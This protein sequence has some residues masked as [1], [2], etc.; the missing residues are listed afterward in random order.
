MDSNVKDLIYLLSCAIKN[1]VP[2]ISEQMDIDALYKL[3]AYHHLSAVLSYSL[4][5]AGIQDSR[6]SSSIARSI[7]RSVIMEGEK[8][9]L[10]ARLEDAGI[11]YAPL[12]GA[13]LK[14]YYPKF[15]MR[16]M[17]DYD[18]LVAADRT[19]DVKDIMVSLGFTVE[20]YDTDSNHDVY[21]KQPVTNFEIHRALFRNF[22]FENET[23][24]FTAYY[25]RVWDILIKDED[26]SCGYHFSNEDFY[27]YMLAHEN[28]H[29]VRK[30]IGIRALLDVFV[31]LRYFPV[32][33]WDHINAGLK[34]LGIVEFE[35]KIRRLSLTLFEEGTVSDEAM[36]DYMLG[37]GTYGNLSNL[38]SNRMERTGSKVKYV[39]KRLIVPIETVKRSYPY[40]YKHRI[41]L[42]FVPIIRVIRKSREG[43]SSVRAEI[44]ALRKIK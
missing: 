8:N 13:I 29:Y 19:G 21:F 12:K 23:E 16:E 17:A 41:L 28:K 18:I 24:N 27:V 14:N 6:I 43:L 15:G 4:Q 42:P 1:T 30:G 10:F 31:F 40:I 22:E 39:L 7:R 11:A 38:V 32:L 25:Q 9:A 34:D 33:D 20:R 3:A 2:L 37:S 44:N 36:L 26:N 35:E 5:S